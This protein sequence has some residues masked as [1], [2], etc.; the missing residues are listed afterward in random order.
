MRR[1][2]LL[3]IG[4]VCALPASSPARAPFQKAIWG[5]VERDGVSQFPIYERLGARLYETSL[6]WDQVARTRPAS[7]SDPDDPAY[8]WPADA[9]RAVAEAGTHGLGVALQLIGAPRWA[10]GRRPPQWAPVNPA[11]F[12]AFAHAASVR[13][14]QVRTWIVWGEPTKRSSFRPPPSAGAYQRAVPRWYARLL[15]AAYRAL[16]DTRRTNLIVGG[17]TFTTGNVRTTDFLRR[18]RLASGKPPPMDLYGHNAFTLRRPDLRNAPVAPG[19]LDFSDLDT[20]ARL[21]DRNIKPGLRIFIDEFTLPTDHANWEFNFHVSRRTQAD[22]LARALRIGRG[23]SR[24]YGL[25]WLSL[26]DD[27]PRPKH[28]EVNR[29]LLDYR[30]R[31]KPAFDAFARG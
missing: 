11:D 19:V 22:W 23:W 17:N 4:L 16:K 3:A 31:L 24:I 8:R 12:A 1:V 13:Y 2:V 6:H 20:L 9:D 7:P 27:P 15:D 26:Y 5:P 30:G 28:D 21:V 29:G 10:N 14:A 25:G 18:L